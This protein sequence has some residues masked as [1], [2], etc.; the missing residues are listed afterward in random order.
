[1]YI[2]SI[3]LM[4]KW[5][6]PFVKRRTNIYTLNACQETGLLIEV[7]CILLHHKL[8]M[9]SIKFNISNTFCIV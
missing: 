2:F 9:A 8:T 1:M 7:S 4:R 3:C 5:Y 6:W